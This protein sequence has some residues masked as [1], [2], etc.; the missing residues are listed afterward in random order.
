MEIS[1]KEEEQI[2]ELIPLE[3][4]SRKTNTPECQILTLLELLCWLILEV[5]FTVNNVHF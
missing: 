2:R 3:R 5:S 1:M 4:S